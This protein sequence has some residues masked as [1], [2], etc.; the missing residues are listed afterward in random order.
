M[1]KTP[2]LGKL[3]SQ[4]FALMQMNQQTL[5]HT[6]KL[7]KPLGITAESEKELLKRLA[8][9]GYI[10]RLIKGIYLVPK[11]IP[12]GGG[13]QPNEYYIVAHVMKLY[14]AKY[15]IGGMTAFHYHGFIQQIPNQITV[16]NDKISTQ[17][18]IGKLS[19]IFIKTKAKRI[20]GTEKIQL[21]DKSTA[22]IAN[23]ART[24]MDA[25]YDWSRYS[26]L[27]E[28]YTW[29]KAYRDNETLLNELIQLTTDYSNK[30]TMRRIGYYLE[31][32]GI[33]SK[34]LK[35]LLDKL[36]PIK[37]WVPLDPYAA[38]KGETNKKWRIIDNV[39][40]HA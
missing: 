25:V 12:P 37:S 24:L 30:S 19:F 27:P 34:I 38:T 2:A 35:P 7:Q 6:G 9:N 32:L 22:T 13:W 17:K 39:T 10:L 15:Y 21:P 3:G 1:K 29:I 14:D 4:F 26:C 20:K 28:A 11:R 23:L 33:N 5:V 36:T 31:S 18:N 16:Y 8:R 40:N